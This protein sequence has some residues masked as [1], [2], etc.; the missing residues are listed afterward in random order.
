MGDLLDAVADVGY[1]RAAHGIEIA[2]AVGIVEPTAA[3]PDDARRRAR[4]LPVEDLGLGVVVAGHG[5]CSGAPVERA[6]SRGRNVAGSP[7][8]RQGREPTPRGPHSAES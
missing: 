6:Q 5:W 4:Q 8:R 1:E 2:P 7:N 3:A